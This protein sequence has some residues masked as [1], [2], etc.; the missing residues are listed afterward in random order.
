MSPA[1]SLEA[2]LHRDLGPREGDDRTH[3][4]EDRDIIL[5]SSAFKRLLSVTQV[6]SGSAGLLLH[7]RLTH[8][9]Q[10]AQVGRRLAEKLKLRHPDL[11]RSWGGVDPDIVETACL[12]HDIGHPPF[13]HLA[14][15]VLDRASKEFGGFEGNAQSFR[16]VTQLGIRSRAY[17]GLNLTRGSLR[18]LLKYPWTYSTR[19]D[20]PNHETGRK[21]KWGAYD[22]DRNVFDWVWETTTGGPIQPKAIEAELM[23]WSDDVTYSVHDVEDFFRAGL[24][25]LH[26]LRDFTGSGIRKERTRFF[27]YVAESERTAKVLTGLSQDDIAKIFDDLMIYAGFR[28]EQPYEGTREDHAS[29]RTFTSRLINRFINAVEMQQ[30]RSYANSTVLIDK[31]KEQEIAILKQLT[32]FYVIEAPGLAIQHEA[33][34]KIIDRLVTVVLSESMER[35]PSGVLPIAYRELLKNRSFSDVEKKRAA[36][37]LIASMTESQ[38]IDFYRRLEGISLGSGLDRVLV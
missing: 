8:S 27:E 9:L 7:T 3:F 4:Q 15:R 16:I 30:P 26:L 29:L 24:I 28:F 34:K 17:P 23:D 1:E 20:D 36:I 14:E 35:K 22:C 21:P 6:A 18:G 38:A 2:R 37:D 19:P 10:V 31:Q 25:P 5:Y 12:A 33:Q 11:A 32:W 13:G